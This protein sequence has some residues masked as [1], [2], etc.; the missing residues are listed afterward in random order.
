MSSMIRRRRDGTFIQAFHSGIPDLLVDLGEQLD[1]MLDSDTPE[2][3]RLFPTA[4]TDD[5]E[6]DAG[7]QILARSSLT[8]QRRASI[9]TVRRT[10]GSEVLTEDELTDWMALTNDLRLVLGTRLDVSEDDDGSELDPDSPEGH[11]MEIYHV[12]GA[13]LHEIV[14]ALSGTLPRGGTE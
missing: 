11:L 4:Y 8:D 13:V 5:E 9:E 1:D 14:A 10:A 3:R 12:L 6:K 7:Y 2:L